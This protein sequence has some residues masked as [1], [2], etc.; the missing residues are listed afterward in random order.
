ME[1]NLRYNL[2]KASEDIR[3][4]LDYYELNILSDVEVFKSLNAIYDS[5]ILAIKL[6]DQNNEFLTKH[7]AFSM[8]QLDRFNMKFSKSQDLTIRRLTEINKK[9]TQDISKEMDKV[10]SS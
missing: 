5:L 6:M 2:L 9:L 10:L 7:F 8:D 1:S 4:V 3:E